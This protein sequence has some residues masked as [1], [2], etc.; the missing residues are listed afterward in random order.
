MIAGEPSD[1]FHAASSTAA[2][3]VYTSNPE[4]RFNEILTG[5]CVQFTVV[6]GEKDHVLLICTFSPEVHATF[7]RRLFVVTL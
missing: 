1:S 5:F 7:T 6:T 2:K 4:E 3:K